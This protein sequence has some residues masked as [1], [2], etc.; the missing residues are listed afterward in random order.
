MTLI[1]Q[2]HFYRD[3]SKEPERTQRPGS[4]SE[5]KTYGNFVY[6]LPIKDLYLPQD[7]IETH[8]ERG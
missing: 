6:H 5:I 7:M 4:I 1:W 8:P 3:K 2:S